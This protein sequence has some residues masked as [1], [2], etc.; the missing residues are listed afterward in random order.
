MRS[1]WIGWV[2]SVIELKSLPHCH[3]KTDKRRMSGEGRGCHLDTKEPRKAHV[4]R[5]ATRSWERAALLTPPN[6]ELLASRSLRRWSVVVLSH[7]FVVLSYGHP[8]KRIQESSMISS[9]SHKMSRWQVKVWL[10]VPD[11]DVQV[12]NQ[13]PTLP[14]GEHFLLYIM[15]KNISTV[16]PPS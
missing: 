4:C 15:W 1:P 7:Q 16:L 12:F 9:I 2:P 5:Q 3:V 13:H 8:R 10:V 14:L 11:S 6:F